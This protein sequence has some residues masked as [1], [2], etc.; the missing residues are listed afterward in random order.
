MDGSSSSSHKG[1]EDIV[2]ARW[3][4]RFFAWLI[5]FII[6][7]IG[8]ILVSMLLFLFSLLFY[9]NSFTSRI[10]EEQQSFTKS[11]NFFISSIVFFLY[12]LYFESTSGQSI[13]KRILN[14][15]TT[16]LEGKIA[17]RKDIAIESF[18]KS[19]LLPFDVTLG[20]IFT[21]ERRQ[22]IFGRLGNTIVIKIKTKQEDIQVD[23]AN[24]R[25]NKD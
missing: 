3:S 22:R 18:G 4:D 1:V 6:V 19:F 11:P 23:S 25:Y 5:D 8:I 14:I 16:T 12:W 7:T 15:K 24:H 9:S 21:N 2:L 13:G 17:K 10:G 20:W